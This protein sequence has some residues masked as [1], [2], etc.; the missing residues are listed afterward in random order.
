MADPGTSDRGCA[1]I[2]PHCPLGIGHWTPPPQPGREYQVSVAVY[3]ELLML[4][5]PLAVNVGFVQCRKLQDLAQPTCL[6]FTTNFLS[7]RS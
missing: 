2:R 7:G 6:R 5:A 4:S 1:I 3:N